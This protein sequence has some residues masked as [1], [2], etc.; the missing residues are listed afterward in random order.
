MADLVCPNG[1]VS[2]DP[3]WCDTC[4]A[5]MAGNS[6]TPSPPS[7]RS[8]PVGLAATPASGIVAPVACPG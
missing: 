3:D 4:G 1:H 8:S 7:P 6:G 2:S 5:P